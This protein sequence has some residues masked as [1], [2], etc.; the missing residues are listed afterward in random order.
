MVELPNNPEQITNP[1]KAKPVLKE[2]GKALK[3]LVRHCKLNELFDLHMKAQKSAPQLCGM[4]EIHLCRA[5]R[6]V[7]NPGN[8]NCFRTLTSFLIYKDLPPKALDTILKK[9]R[10]AG[11]YGWYG[12]DGIGDLILTSGITENAALGLIPVYNN[13][14]GK[15]ILAELGERE[16]LPDK[17]RDALERAVP[18]HPTRRIARAMAYFRRLPNPAKSIHAPKTASGRGGGSG[19]KLRQRMRA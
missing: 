15:N 14:D 7:G 11:I 9:C 10:R 3:H 13:R 1:N 8:D 6:K 4:I 17:V 2:F 18:D 16:G 19:G 12:L 5:I